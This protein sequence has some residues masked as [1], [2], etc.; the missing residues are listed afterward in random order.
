MPARPHCWWHGWERSSDAHAPQR[1]TFMTLRGLKGTLKASSSMCSSNRNFTYWFCVWKLLSKQKKTNLHLTSKNTS[2]W[3]PSSPW[4]SL[5]P[6]HRCF[7]S[8]ES[9]SRQL[10]RYERRQ[11][12]CTSWSVTKWSQDLPSFYLVLSHRFFGARFIHFVKLSQVPWSVW[13]SFEVCRHL[14]NTSPEERPSTAKERH[15]WLPVYSSRREQHPTKPLDI[16]LTQ[17][18]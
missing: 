1:G 5:R 14:G 12:S 7:Q 15:Q 16:W 10:D 2:S 18:M 6:C 3:D 4:C 17:P 9:S 13:D 11:R 8:L